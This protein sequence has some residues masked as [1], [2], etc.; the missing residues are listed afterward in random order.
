MLQK[1]SA[2][3]LCSFALWSEGT[4]ILCKANKNNVWKQIFY[5]KVIKV[6]LTNDHSTCQHQQ[7]DGLFPP[8]RILKYFFFT[9]DRFENVVTKKSIQSRLI[10]LSVQ[11]NLVPSQLNVTGYNSV[12]VRWWLKTSI[13]CRLSNSSMQ[14][15]MNNNATYPYI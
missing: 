4:Y 7:S 10:S 15:S 14:T 9:H 2:N 12:P 5:L 8:K 1:W 3:N 11:A 6:I 13:L